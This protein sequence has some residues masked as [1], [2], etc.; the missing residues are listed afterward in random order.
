MSLKDDRERI[1]ARLGKL[2][3]LADFG[4]AGERENAK[5]AMERVAEKYGIDLDNLNEEKE[6]DYVLEFKRGWRL[7]LI[8]QLV[9]LGRIEW[10][11]SLD[12]PHCNIYLRRQG[13]KVAYY[14]VRCTAAQWTEL[15]AKFDIL[16]RD[17]ERQLRLFFRAFLEA[18]DLLVPSAP[19]STKPSAQEIADAMDA[20][21]MAQG[22]KKSS[23]RKQ[24]TATRGLL[25]EEGGTAA[26]RQN[27]DGE[28]GVG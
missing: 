13:G 16:A 3:A 11:G 2:K 10:H 1:L 15:R 20:L 25:A 8:R 9:G 28:K 21:S 14:F 17:Y 7:D 18:N 6:T 5:A 12:A 27:G 19:D 23:V 4:A 22:I 26:A 24:I